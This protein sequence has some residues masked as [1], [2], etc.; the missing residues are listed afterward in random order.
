MLKIN[1]FRMVEYGILFAK[2]GVITLQW[3]V[4]EQI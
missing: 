4:E 2:L 3:V 1:N